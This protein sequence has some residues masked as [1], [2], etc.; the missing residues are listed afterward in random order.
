PRTPNDKV[1]RAALPE[2]AHDV[3]PE[4]AP[5]TPL[6]ELLCD[7]FAEVL[8]V[9]EVGIDDSFFDLGGHS[10]LATRLVIRI[11]RVFRCDLEPRALF[12]APTPAG[13]A[14]V[15]AAGADATQTPVTAV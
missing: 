4:S 13:L 12:G 3:A 10:L 5:R 2:P 14:E 15:L 7:L 1:D 8:G 11:R 6:Q 9:P